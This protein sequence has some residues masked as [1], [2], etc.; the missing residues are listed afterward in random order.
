[1]TDRHGNTGNQ[2]AKKAATADSHLHIRVSSDT[3]A[4]YEERARGQGMSLSKWATQT[5]SSACKEEGMT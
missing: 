3:K 1:M 4:A 2:H 5:L